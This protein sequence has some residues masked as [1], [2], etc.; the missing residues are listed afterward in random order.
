MK[1]TLLGIA[2]ILAM[3]SSANAVDTSQIKAAC[4]SSDKTL[5]VERNQ[6]CIP[7]NP[8]ENPNYEQY[9]N[10]VFRDVYPNVYDGEEKDL[11]N[12]FAL[13]R[14]LDC[15]A[16]DHEAYQGNTVVCYGDDVVVFEFNYIFEKNLRQITD[17]SLSPVAS[18]ICT[19]ILNGE[20]LYKDVDNE[21]EFKCINANND[22]CKK[23]DVGNYSYPAISIKEYLRFQQI[24]GN[25]YIFKN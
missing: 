12:L 18:L 16:L 9:C 4:Q 19:K 25:C 11:V 10:R 15:K 14:E 7:R 8:C 2:G 5:W 17:A 3:I 24:A 1:K 23:V 21:N 13:T 20:N 22:W 6:V